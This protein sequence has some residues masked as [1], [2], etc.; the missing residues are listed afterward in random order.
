MIRE[1]SLSLVL[2]FLS[3]PMMGQ[4]NYA[5]DIAPIIYKNCSNCHRPGEIGPFPLT[6]Y[7][8]VSNWGAMI[9]FVTG[10]GYMPPWKPDSEYSTFL[11]ES[12]LTQTEIDLIAD[13]VDSGMERGD[14]TLEPEF[15]DYPEGSLLGEPDLVLEMTEAH[16]HRGNNSDSYYYFVLP[17]GLTQDRIVKTMEF[18]PGNP[19]IVHHALIFEDVNGI[20]RATDAQTPEYGFP[21]FGSFNGNQ[22]DVTFLEEK[23]FP[24][25]APGQKA[26]RYPDG[27][28]QV[29]QA[30]ADLAVQ[31]H[32]APIPTDEWDQSKINIFIADEDEQVDRI[33][34]QNVFLPNRLP[35]GFLSFFIPANENKEFV[36]SWRMNQDRSLIGIFPHSHLLGQEW[37]AWVEHTDG[38]R[39]NLISIPDWDFNWQSQYYFDKLIKAESGSR[40]FARAVYDN[41]ANNLDNPNSPP[42][43]VAWGDKTTDEM[44]Y[45][46]F[47]F[48]PYEEGD[49][50]IRFENGSNAVAEQST[51]PTN[52]YMSDIMPNPV[53]D[54][55]YLDFWL[56]SGTVLDVEIV[57]ITGQVIRH[58]RS[59][60]FFNSGSNMVDFRTSSLE[61]GTYL[62]NIRGRRIN[63]SQKF[64]KI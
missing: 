20:A 19:E 51:S 28:G 24:P 8:E 27:I 22:N 47:L 12:E 64:S 10:T 9:K 48:L 21:S 29:L 49:E 17:T 14:L 45:M 44:F 43:L 23:Q 42:Q 37:E 6:D 38:S 54:R 56:P 40:I 30:G 1:L 58:L 3:L 36:G 25:Y 13:W 15:P 60:E 7:N 16:L 31:I 52:A 55:V 4:T 39:T 63:L 50:D 61:T 33:V 32:Y 53:Q 34:D 35:G 41:T 62:V 26:L 2:A 46:P 11:G 59:A 18:R 57:D 5:Q